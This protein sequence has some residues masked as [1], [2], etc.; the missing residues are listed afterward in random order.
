MKI[1]VFCPSMIG[2]TVMATP[3]F[4][5]LRG[6]FPDARITAIIRPHV[7]PV[8]AG[9][10]WFD[11]MILLHHRSDRREQR[12]AAVVSLLR[13][14]RNDVAILLPNSFRTALIAWMSGIPRRIGYL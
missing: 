1:A 5:A 4:R 3:T 8:L 10:H 13:Q 7:A 9:T 11:E 12:T 2:D 6:Q 14:M